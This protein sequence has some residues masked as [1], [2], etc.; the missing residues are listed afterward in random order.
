M[1]KLSANTQIDLRHYDH[2][3]L[4]HAHD[5]HQ[6]VLPIEGVLE[7]E[8]DGVASN[9]MSSTAA[10]IPSGQAHSCA[11][12]GDNSFLIIDIPAPKNVTNN[13]WRAVSENPFVKIDTSFL[14]YCT[15][16]ATEMQQTSFSRL[17]IS[18]TGNMLVNALARFVG[19]SNEPLPTA[20]TKA[21][22]FIDA[23]FSYPLTI[24][25]IARAAG[26]SDSRLHTQFKSHLDISPKL[27]LTEIR[28]K[29]AASMLEETRLSI[30]E[31]ALRVGY[32]DQSAFTRAFQR[33]MGSSPSKFRHAG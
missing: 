19:V 26:A 2:N 6:L 28:L 31:I 33:H 32:D 14:G 1:Q 25:D 5:H 3:I 29:N 15:F 30:A 23:N 4:S 16:I 12:T 20:L 9:V 27:Y 24:K 8:I 22:H 7:M 17:D 11:S 18:L 13:L 21:V 10:V